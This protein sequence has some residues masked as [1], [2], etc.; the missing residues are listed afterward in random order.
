MFT[1]R[2]SQLVDEKNSSGQ[3]P[4]RTA[5]RREYGGGR[6]RED[7]ARGPGRWWS[8]GKEQNMSKRKLWTE[9]MSYSELRV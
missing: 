4:G 6:E 2:F 9:L 1:Y 8:W 5:A 7:E 3:R